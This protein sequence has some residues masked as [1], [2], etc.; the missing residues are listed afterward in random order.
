M[1]WFK[2]DDQFA[3]SPKALA[4]GNA[5][6]GLW[7][8]AGSWAAAQLTDGDIP[9]TMVSSLGGR[10]ADARKLV[11]VGLWHS[12]G[13]GCDACP[14]PKRGHYI[15]HGWQEYQPTRED[16]QRKRA[17]ARERMA[18][19]RGSQR[20]R[21]NSERTS[22]SVRDPRPDPARPTAA[23]AAE[24]G[25]SGGDHPAIDILMSKLRAQTALASLRSD[26]LRPE[27]VATI[28]G[29]IE[30]H[31]DA[32][33]VDAAVKTTGH[34]APRMVQAYIGTWEALATGRSTL[35]VIDT[36]PRCDICNARQTDHDAPAYSD[37]PFTERN[38]A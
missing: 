19:R 6:C 28:V 17:E 14:D 12:H 22:Q 7:V 30:Q 4:A 23:A 36:T 33:L 26:K 32:A 8:R 10:A 13:H 16:V 1:T 24:D 37:H 3:M 20:V 15:F 34:P 38:S 25:G 35:R 31:G 18:T 2:V 27:Q 9:S 11:E 21:A 29:L 5:A